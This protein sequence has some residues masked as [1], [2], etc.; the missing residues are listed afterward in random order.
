MD[1]KETKPDINPE[2]SLEGLMLKLMIQ[3]FD[4]L[5][6]TAN[7]LTKS[8]MLG[9]TEGRRRRG[10]QRMRWLAGMTDAMNVNLGSLRETVRDTEATC[11][12]VHGFAKD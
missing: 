10:C 6:G 9:K 5:I 1:C 3:Y 12:A 11:A 7:S 2:Y 4:H 8:L